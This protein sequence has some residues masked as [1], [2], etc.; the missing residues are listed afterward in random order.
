MSR[1]FNFCGMLVNSLTMTSGRLRA[2]AFATDF[3]SSASPTTASMPRAAKRRAPAGLR[4]KTVGAWPALRNWSTSGLP[5]APVPPAMK[6][7]IDK[8]PN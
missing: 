4:V 3:A 5:T 6:T 2:T 7:R 8:P 1:R